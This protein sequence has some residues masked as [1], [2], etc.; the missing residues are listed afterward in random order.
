M[1]AVTGDFEEKM[2]NKWKDALPSIFVWL[3]AAGVVY[4][5]VNNAAAHKEKKIPTYIAN[6]IEKYNL[7]GDLS[8]DYYQGFSDAISYAEDHVEEFASGSEYEDRLLDAGYDTG[9]SD[10]YDQGLRDARR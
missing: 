6:M 2:K 8:K 5:F 4:F 10:G 9:Y 1:D 7:D 3:I